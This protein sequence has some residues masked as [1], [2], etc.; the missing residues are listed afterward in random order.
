MMSNEQ[1]HELLERALPDRDPYS[2]PEV[3]RAIAL[4]RRE[5]ARRRL[6]AYAAGLAGFTVL[7][8]AIVVVPSAFGDPTG[9]T[10]VGV[11]PLVSSSPLPTSPAPP[12]ASAGPD[13]KVT[14][15]GPPPSS[16]PPYVANVATARRLTT[17]VKAAMTRH[18]PDATF[19]RDKGRNWPAFTLRTQGDYYLGGS[20]VTDAAGSGSVTVIVQ[21]DPQAWS[22]DTTDSVTVGLVSCEEGY[23]PA[24]EHWVYTV[25]N[26]AD[27]GRADIMHFE[28]LVTKADQTLVQISAENTTTMKSLT[29]P[30]SRPTPP[31]T[32]EQLLAVALTPALTLNP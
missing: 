20:W 3:E 7:V 8:V 26:D 1:V 5:L 10:A 22:C 14:I 24:G 6:T 12:T 17:V 16:G 4:G 30:V 11:P 25:L 15:S 23:G 29:A 13:G 31:M 28:I 2:A 9:S 18:L 21:R 19:A 32:K 27:N